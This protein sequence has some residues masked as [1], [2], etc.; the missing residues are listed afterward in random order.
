MVNKRE[1]A[2]ILIRILAA[3]MLLQA[4]SI[5]PMS[6]TFGTSNPLIFLLSHEFTTFVISV[7]LWFAAP[8]LSKL[9]VRDFTTTKESIEPIADYHFE[10]LIFSGI[11]LVLVATSIPA[12][13]NMV[14]YNSAIET[15]NP[16]APTKVQ[17]IASSKGFTAKYI[18]KIICGL[19]LLIFSEKLCRLFSKIRNKV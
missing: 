1:L 18:A 6:V 9:I 13:A 4:L 19:F 2:V 8:R 16:D 3:Y 10:A 15:L 7:A 14:A 12:I 11:G 5:L 17:M